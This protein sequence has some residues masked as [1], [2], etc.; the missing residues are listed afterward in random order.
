MIK[1]DTL[2]STMPE[3]FRYRQF[4]VTALEAA[5]KGGAYLLNAFKGEVEL[6]IESK[7]NRND[8]VTQVDLES[9]KM[10]MEHIR[11]AHPD[12]TFLA[13]ESGESEKRAEYR[14]I[15]DPLDGTTNFIHGLPIWAVSI[16]LQKNDDVIAGVVYAPCLG[17]VTCAAAGSGAFQNGKKIKVSEETDFARA[18]LLTGFP[19]KAQKH[20]D[21]YM[22]TFKELFARC[23]GMRRAGSAAIDLSWVASG[24][25]DGFWELSLGPWD[26]AAGTLL[27]REAGGIVTDIH[28]D[29]KNFMKTGNIVAGNPSTHPEIL[30]T[31]RKN[32]TNLD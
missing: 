4:L 13:E 32:F 19:F 11:V 5:E 15:I 1:I 27:V 6:K 14:W 17:E 2:L 9:E 21:I 23:S 16:A 25:A 10:I 12:H 29:D 26:I 24:K 18:L 8:Y 30:N 31:T 20:I 22:E 28:G 3:D 7:E